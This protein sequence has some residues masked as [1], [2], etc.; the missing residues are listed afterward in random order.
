MLDKVDPPAVP[1]GYGLSLGFYCL[2]ETVKTIQLLVEGVSTDSDTAQEKD[3]RSK[4]QEKSL[5]E[6]DEG[7][8]DDFIV[9]S[10]ITDLI[11]FEMLTTY[12]ITKFVPHSTDTQSLARD[13]P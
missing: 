3:D 6:E 11:A 9:L 10:V 5:S 8:W 12:A 2:M 1:D 13:T 7:R 4:A